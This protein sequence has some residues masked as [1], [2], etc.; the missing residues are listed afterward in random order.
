[1]ANGKSAPLAIASAP[2]AFAIAIY[3]PVCAETPVHECEVMEARRRAG[4]CMHLGLHA[5]GT[6][7]HDRIQTIRHATAAAPHTSVAR[8]CAQ[9]YRETSRRSAAERAAA[10]GVVAEAH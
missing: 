9:A 1:M 6:P 4:L 2:I 7:V 10:F 5:V 8:N 3:R